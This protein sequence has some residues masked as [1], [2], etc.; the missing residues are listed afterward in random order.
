MG[1]LTRTIADLTT[2]LTTIGQT[3]YTVP[4]GVTSL[5]FKACGVGGGGGA[6]LIVISGYSQVSG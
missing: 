5:T 4:V 6:G 1:V 2:A 3:T